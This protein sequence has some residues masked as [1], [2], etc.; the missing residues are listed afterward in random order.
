MKATK[1]MI[2]RHA[3]KPGTYGQY[4]YAG[5]DQ[6]GV[7]DKKSLI[8]IGWQRA[9]GLA[10]LF[11]PTCGP[12]QNSELA[13]PDV[14]YAASP[15]NSAPSDSDDSSSAD[16]DGSDPSKRPY[17][18][19]IPLSC[20]AGVQIVDSRESTAFQNM[21]MDVLSFDVAGANTCTILISWQHQDILPKK[22]N[23]D[24]I[25]ME[26]IK[27]TGGQ[28]PAKVPAGPWPGERYDLVFVFDRPS[29]SGPFTAFS[30]VPQ[31]LLSGD[32]TKHIH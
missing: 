26:L 32:S 17:Q 9:G 20:K 8:P 7:P 18:T 21:V 22:K 13:V 6:F 27:Q 14:I 23:S 2:I 15:A 16:K 3:E 1:V 30:Q 11:S 25:V 28:A 24:S 5:V 12:L 29:G 4:T 10:S 19:V 31:M